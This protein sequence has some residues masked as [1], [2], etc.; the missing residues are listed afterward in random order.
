MKDNK[1]GGATWTNHALNRMRERGI[2]KEY[3]IESIKNPDFSEKNDKGGIRMTKKIYDKTITSVINKNDRNENIV[4]SIWM[5][6]PMIGT[7]D[8]KKKQ[9]YNEYRKAGIGKKIWLTILKQLGI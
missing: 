4:I 6:P 1:F 5:D 7:Q 3:A 8:H 9:R 2:P